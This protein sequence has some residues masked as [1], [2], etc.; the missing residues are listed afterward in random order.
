MSS[1]GFSPET[2]HEPTDDGTSGVGEGALVARSANAGFAASAAA[3]ATAAARFIYTYT[4]IENRKAA[5][6]SS[7]TSTRYAGEKYHE[8]NQEKRTRPAGSRIGP[9]VSY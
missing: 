6:S 9:W 5:A 2:K 7:T 1:V 8:N 4:H 3:A